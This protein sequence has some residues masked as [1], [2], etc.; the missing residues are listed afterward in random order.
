MPDLN[1]HY[2][3]VRPFPLG[4]EVRGGEE[5]KDIADEEREMGWFHC[6]FK[7]NDIFC[8]RNVLR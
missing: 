6:R 1:T 3:S 8:K 2:F 5:R 7:A 4:S